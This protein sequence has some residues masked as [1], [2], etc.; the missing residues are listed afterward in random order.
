[1][2]KKNILDLKCPDYI[3]NTRAYIDLM[4]SIDQM[5]K[6]RKLT[7]ALEIIT[8][9]ST[10]YKRNHQLLAMLECEA[11]KIYILSDL[12]YLQWIGLPSRDDT[13][14]HLRAEMDI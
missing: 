13:P 8:E 5:E 4:Y 11:I 6:K 12:S 9:A 3:K 2:E 7:E 1:M 14:R 10:M